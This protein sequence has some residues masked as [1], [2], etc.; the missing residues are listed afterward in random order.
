MPVQGKK[1]GRPRLTEEEKA[2]RKEERERI[3]Q[4]NATAEALGKKRR[5]RPKKDPSQPLKI[6][7]F[8]EQQIKKAKAQKL[9]LPHELLLLWA[10]GIEFGGLEP[11]EAQQIYAA[12][13]AA[14]Y[15]APKL[16][17]VAVKQDVRVRAVISAQPMSQEQWEEKYIQTEEQK[18]LAD[19]NAVTSTGGASPIVGTLGEVK[20]YGLENVMGGEGDALTVPASYEIISD[21]KET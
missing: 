14:P 17:N 9:L 13:A 19:P 20:S 15:Y 12:V 4:A 5:G 1:R 21:D 11:T 3:A 8:S 7:G 16:A 2:R 6:K 10:N 18:Q